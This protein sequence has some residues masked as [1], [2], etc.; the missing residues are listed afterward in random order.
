MMKLVLDETI[1][2]LPVT[3]LRHVIREV[4]KHRKVIE[5][6]RETKQRLRLK[7]FRK[8]GGEA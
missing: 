1:G 6:M 4:N 8:K 2:L 5:N 3:D 7:Y